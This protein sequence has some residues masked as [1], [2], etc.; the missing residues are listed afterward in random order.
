MAANTRLKMPNGREG[1]VTAP[2]PS[3][4]KTDRNMGWWRVRWSDGGD[5]VVTGRFV[6][7]FALPTS[8]ED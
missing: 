8:E 4:W 7:T 5:S 3:F 2:V 1:V 6:R